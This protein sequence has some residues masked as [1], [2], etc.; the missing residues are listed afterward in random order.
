ML[1]RPPPLACPVC[2]SEN[3]SDVDALAV[4][5]CAGCGIEFRPRVRVPMRSYG[6]NDP[7]KPSASG[8][9][10]VGFFVMCAVGIGIREAERSPPSYN[11]SRGAPTYQPVELPPI[12]LPPIEAPPLYDASTLF[13]E[14]PDPEPHRI[15]R[16]DGKLW[17]SG[18]VPVGVRR[19]SSVSVRAHFRSSQ[20][21]ELDSV[22]AVVACPRLAELPCPWALDGA[23]EAFATDSVRFESAGVE[24]FSDLSPQAWVRVEFD[25]QGKR[26]GMVADPPRF[27]PRRAKLR[28]AEHEVFIDFD[29][30]DESRMLLRTERLV[31]FDAENQVLAVL[32]PPREGWKPKRPIDLPRL[33]VPVARYELWVWGSIYEPDPLTGLDQ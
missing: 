19:F 3:A 16:R 12:E 24:W 26:T 15:I 4:R 14:P 6:P 1:R 30:R 13:P 11:P 29:L 9:A 7:S 18:V 20:G 32:T 22:E 10:L 2:A 31:L 5:R 27:E 33:D 21:Y 17:A 25:A 28:L 8:W 23:V